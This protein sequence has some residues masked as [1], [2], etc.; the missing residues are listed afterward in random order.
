MLGLVLGDGAGGEGCLLPFFYTCVFVGVGGEGVVVVATSS[1]TWLTHG[2]WVVSV[3]GIAVSLVS[4]L[5]AHVEPYDPSDLG[6]LGWCKSKRRE[7]LLS[8]SA[9]HT[10]TIHTSRKATSLNYWLFCVLS[11]SIGL[12]S[13]FSILIGTNIL[14]LQLSSSLPL[15]SSTFSFSSLSTSQSFYLC[16]A[17]NAYCSKHGRVDIS[18]LIKENI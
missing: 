7:K 12:P 2:M 10:S 9:S 14:A 11:M 16:N 3:G 13:M 1:C 6:T 4:S 5:M 15:S 17:L 8:T 18:P